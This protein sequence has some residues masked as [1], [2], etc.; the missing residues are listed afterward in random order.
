MTVMMK[1]KKGQGLIYL[2]RSGDRQETSLQKQLDWAL[3]AA[4]D[5]NVQIDAATEDVTRMQER[6]LHAHKSLRLDNAITGADLTRPGLQQ[7][8]QDVQ[9]YPQISHIFV[10]AR[11][12]LGRPDSPVDMMLIEENIRRLGVTLVLASGVIEPHSGE[13][14]RLGEMVSMLFDYHRSGKF[15]KELAEQMIRTQLQLAKQGYWTGGV[16]PYGFTRA[17]IDAQGNII[18]TLPRGK[19]VR[20]AGCHVVLIPQEEEKIKTWIHILSRKE[21]GWGYKRIVRDL[22]ERKIPSPGAGSK[23]TDRGVKHEVSGS[24]SHTTVRAICKN[25]TIL[26]LLDYGRHSEGKH[27]RLGPGIPRPL[28]TSDGVSKK[29]PKRVINTPNIVVTAKLPCKPRFDPERWEKINAETKRRGRKQQGIPRTRDPARYPL[30]CRVYDLSA[31][32]NS[33]MY[34]HTSGQ[35]KLYTCGRYMRTGGAECENNSVDAEAILHFSLATLTE[36][37]DRLGAR[38]ELR[39]LLLDRAQQSQPLVHENPIRDKRMV[40][41]TQIEKLRQ[42]VVIAQQNLAFEPEQELRQAIREEFTR[43]KAELTAAEDQLKTLPHE[44]SICMRN[45]QE[46]AEAALA[47]ID[48][49]QRI[50]EDPQARTEIGPLL[51]KLG[52]RIGLHFVAGIKG[53]KRPVRLLAGGVVA[54]GSQPFSNDSLERENTREKG[55]FPEKECA[56]SFNDAPAEGGVGAIYSPPQSTI[57]PNCLREGISSTK[58]SRETRTPIELFAQGIATLTPAIRHLLMAA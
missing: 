20:Q 41:E 49:F 17:L 42:K 43:A 52:F 27:R 10:Y 11:D 30:S 39:R 5:Q 55:N 8:I 1:R 34:G 53:N 45:P 13:D 6:G 3:V 31:D 22:N 25:R 40:L 9:E 7:L 58:G 12:R 26:G 21:Q 4:R 33:I 18:E 38:D 23:R 50:A 28:D 19:R 51:E 2:R 54:F 57:T 56:I 36:L 46:E 48:E 37:V 35:R 15:L 44:T 24:W 29:G 16:P 47:L 14:S 32:C